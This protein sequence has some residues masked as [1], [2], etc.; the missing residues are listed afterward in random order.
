[1]AQVEA[2]LMPVNEQT[3]QRLLQIFNELISH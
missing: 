2:Y 1:M 3:D